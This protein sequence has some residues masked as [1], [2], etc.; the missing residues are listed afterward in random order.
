MYRDPLSGEVEVKYSSMI[1]ALI[2][3][4]FGTAYAAQDEQVYSEAESDDR[5]ACIE[6]A[7]ADEVEEGDQFDKYIESCLQEKIAQ[8]EKAKAS[9]G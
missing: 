7:I 4:L 3:S 6:A 2:F 1:V 8:K 9:N 5:A